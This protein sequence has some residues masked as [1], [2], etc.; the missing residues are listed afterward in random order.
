MV[1]ERC[2]IGHKTNICESLLLGVVPALVQGSLNRWLRLRLALQLLSPMRSLVMRGTTQHC[3][4]IIQIV[5]W[6][7]EAAIE[8]KFFG[9]TLRASPNGGLQTSSS[10]KAL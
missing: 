10:G 8:A 5:P 9:S 4:Q 1:G 7:A 6:R 2:F 3:N